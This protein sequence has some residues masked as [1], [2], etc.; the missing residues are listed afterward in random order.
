[1]IDGKTPPSLSPTVPQMGG[2]LKLE[3]EADDD[4]PRTKCPRRDTTNSP[5]PTHPPPTSRRR[6][7]EGTEVGVASSV[8]NL[9]GGGGGGGST[10]TTTA[11]VGA[12]RMSSGPRNPP[13]SSV[14]SSGDTPS[15]KPVRLCQVCGDIAKSLHFGG[16]SCDSCKAFFRRSVQNDAYKH[17]RCGGDQKCAIS[18]ASRKFCKYCRFTKCESIGMTKSWVMSEE[19]RL[20]LMKTRL[21]KRMMYQSGSAGSGSGGGGGVGSVN[22]GGSGGRGT[23]SGS[24]SSSV[25]PKDSSSSKN[26]QPSYQQSGVL[27]T[28]QPPAHP[29]DLDSSGSSPNSSPPT[30]ITGTVAPIQYGPIPPPAPHHPSEGLH[31]P[32]T[33]K[34]ESP[35][36]T[37]CRGIKRESDEEDMSVERVFN[38]ASRYLDAK[39]FEFIN[40]VVSNIKLVEQ[41][42]P[43]PENSQSDVMSTYGRFAE[44]LTKFLRQFPEFSSLPSVQQGAAIKKNITVIALVFASSFLKEDTGSYHNVH[45]P[46][47]PMITNMT[48]IQRA[49]SPEVFSKFQEILSGLRMFNV[50]T[51]MAYL[52]VLIIVFNM[53]GQETHLNNF[54][55]ILQQY[56]AWRFGELNGKSIYD[57]LIRALQSLKRH[58]ELFESMVVRQRSITSSSSSAL[59]STI[60]RHDCLISGSPTTEEVKSVVESMTGEQIRQMLNG[61]DIEQMKQMLQGNGLEQMKQMLQTMESEITQPSVQESSLISSPPPL[62]CNSPQSMVQSP[63][64]MLQSPHSMLPSPHS[65]LQSPQS[66][67]Q[68]PHSMM[69]SPHS[70]HQPPPSPGILQSPTAS[71]TQN[72]HTMLDISHSL[73]PSPNSSVSQILTSSSNLLNQYQDM[74]PGAFLNSPQSLELSQ[75]L[76]D[77]SSPSPHPVNL[78]A[79]PAPYIPNQES[80]VLEQPLPETAYSDRQSPLEESTYL[81]P[82]PYP[83]APYSPAPL[84]DQYNKGF[85]ALFSPL[86]FKEEPQNVS[87]SSNT[88]S[89]G[90]GLSVTSSMSSPLSSLLTSPAPSHSSLHESD[91]SLSNYQEPEHGNSL[92]AAP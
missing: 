28:Y 92:G 51:R 7:Q 57:G 24:Y 17:F 21:T 41:E 26:S 65:M 70:I 46:N 1:M 37:M 8:N 10:T 83:Q 5:P 71:I 78:T 90:I 47:Q 50:D 39:E 79:S 15:R 61:M 91:N 69:E 23:N 4:Q 58:S 48:M 36:R 67:I 76:I 12:A 52:L 40:R 16:L 9:S 19:E 44:R 38:P 49:M 33:T 73:S 77:I 64:S 81:N 35:V 89:S 6:G 66:I 75:S 74:K 88:S 29:V 87:S 68:S 56:I 80:Y 53:D 45:S 42:L 82:P 86:P 30:P 14:P 59:I 11:P 85:M 55:S 34:E 54:Q 43:Y 60:N 62:H 22:T 3:A 27:P 25:C 2:P 13:P 20:Q 72:M 18:I 84:S 32:V 63:H 31:H